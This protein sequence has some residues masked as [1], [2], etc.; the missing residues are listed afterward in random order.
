MQLLF[1]IFVLLTRYTQS[2]RVD[3]NV[4]TY[5]HQHPQRSGIQLDRASHVLPNQKIKFGFSSCLYSTKESEGAG[6]SLSKIDESDENIQSMLKKAKEL[7]DEANKAEIVL[8]EEKLTIKTKKY[9]PADDFV[10]EM[11]QVLKYNDPIN[12]SDIDDGRSAV[13]ITPAEEAREKKF[14]FDRMKNNLPPKEILLLAV[15]RLF[16]KRENNLRLFRDAEKIKSNIPPDESQGF[17]IGNIFNVEE[18]RRSKAELEVI[19]YEIEAMR[20]TLLCEYIISSVEAIASED[21][22]RN[23]PS[24]DENIFKINEKSDVLAYRNQR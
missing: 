12:T 2:F 1:N 7:R 9:Q 10:E 11:R 20:C 5:R 23:G 18:N 19:Q 17:I 16:E 22:K 4:I 21:E 24:L 6:S 15:E 13:M 14:I 8:K 3:R